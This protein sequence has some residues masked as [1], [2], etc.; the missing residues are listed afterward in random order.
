LK[1]A[2]LLQHGVLPCLLQDAM[3]QLDSFSKSDLELASVASKLYS[4]GSRIKFKSTSLAFVDMLVSLLS[5]VH[6]LLPQS[7]QGSS[8][9]FRVCPFGF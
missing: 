3:L 8:L 2:G 7:A 6:R 1:S 9:V 5:L 4:S